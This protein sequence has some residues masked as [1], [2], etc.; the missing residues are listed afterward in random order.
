MWLLGALSLL[1]TTVVLVAAL[2][3]L[4]N[5]PADP[6]DEEE[7]DGEGEAVAPKNGLQAPAAGGRAGAAAPGRPQAAGSAGPAAVQPKGNGPGRQGLD[8]AALQLAVG[9]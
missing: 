5:V 7:D 6:E 4:D 9:L 1:I 2:F 8:E 3:F